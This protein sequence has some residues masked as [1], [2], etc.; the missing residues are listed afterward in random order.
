MRCSGLLKDKILGL[1]KKKKGVKFIRFRD[2]LGNF[3][4]FFPDYWKFDEDVAVMEGKYTISFYSPSGKET[5]N[6]AVDARLEENLDFD[7]YAH[8]ELESPYSGVIA[9]LQKREF[10]GMPAFW[11]EYSLESQGEDYFG[12]GVMF[13]TGRSIF[14]LSW[15][16]PEKERDRLEGLFKHILKTLT[17]R[18]R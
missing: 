3:E 1:F 9:D 14:S 6:I 4:M 11:R 5:F 17:V 10:R 7:K 12:G 13:Y 8:K 18:H 15:S 16:A 2:P